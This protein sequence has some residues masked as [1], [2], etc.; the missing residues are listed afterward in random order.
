VFSEKKKDQRY[1]SILFILA[2][3]AQL[4]FTSFYRIQVVERGIKINHAMD[5]PLLT[6]RAF[7]V[8]IKTIV[9]D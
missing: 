7:I 4:F 1:L 9:N 8:L 2:L 5:I 3:H 6:E